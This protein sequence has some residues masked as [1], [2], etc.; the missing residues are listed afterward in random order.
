[1]ARPTT[2]KPERLL[3][4]KDT[5]ALCQ[6]SE[7]TIRRWIETKELS[8][9]KLGAQWRIRSRDLDLFIRDHLNW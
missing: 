8:A 7:K 6:V 9:A 1:M 3:T 4:I 5:A 2:N